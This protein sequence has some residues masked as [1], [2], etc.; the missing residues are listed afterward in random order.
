M[1]CWKRKHWKIIHLLLTDRDGSDSRTE[2]TDDVF[3][4]TSSGRGKK[5]PTWSQ[6]YS[7]AFQSVIQRQ[8]DSYFPFVFREE[9]EKWVWFGS[10][11]SEKRQKEEGCWCGV[12]VTLWQ[13]RWK[14]LQNWKTN[15]QILIYRWR[16][17]TRFIWRWPFL[18]GWR[19]RLTG[20]NP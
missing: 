18:A 1:R 5:Q 8:R 15:P 7:I 6:Q 2:G 3:H 16:N 9:L 10:W 19:V 11:N 4:P 14:K 20:I 13:R 17:S 12:K